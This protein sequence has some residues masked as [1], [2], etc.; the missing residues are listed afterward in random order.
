MMD[1]FKSRDIT[2]HYDGEPLFDVIYTCPVDGTFWY[3]FEVY[4]T[5]AEADECAASMNATGLAPQGWDQTKIG[6]M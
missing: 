3:G 5:R 6:P 1:C 4:S 2:E